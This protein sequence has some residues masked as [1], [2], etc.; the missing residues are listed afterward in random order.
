M[1]ADK[2]WWVVPTTTDEEQADLR[3]MVD[4]PDLTSELVR[5]ESFVPEDDV[6]VTHEGRRIG[7]ANVTELGEITMELTEYGADMLGRIEAGM[8]QLLPSDYERPSFE[9]IAKMAPMGT[10][11]R[12]WYEHKIANNT[13][14]GERMDM[15]TYYELRFDDETPAQEVRD[16]TSVEGAKAVAKTVAGVTGKRVNLVKITPIDINAPARTRSTSAD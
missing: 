2:V 10:P 7:T 8:F 11:E 4:L 1:S 6:P 14:G 13:P 16:V 15:D 9:D 5:I 12:L 3:A